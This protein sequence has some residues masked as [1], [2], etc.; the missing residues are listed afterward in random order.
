MM[1]RGDEYLI[2]RWRSELDADVDKIDDVTTDRLA[3]IRRN[4]LSR[5][6]A[7]QS[8]I[9]RMVPAIAFTASAIVLVLFL[10]VPD[11]SISQLDLDAELMEIVL[12]QEEL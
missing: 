3:Q 11:G 9:P 1:K 8:F 7:C 6:V 2:E 5:P 12:A 4:A 10:R